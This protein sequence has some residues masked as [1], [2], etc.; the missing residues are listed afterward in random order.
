MNILVTK[1]NYLGDAVTFLPTLAALT[2][3]LPESTITIVATEVGRQVFEGHTQKAAFCTVDRKRIHTWAAS[4]ILLAAIAQLRSRRYACS[5]HSHDEPSFSYLLARCLRIQR[6][7]GFAS[8][9]GRLNWLLSEKLP[10]DGGRNVVDLNL[11]LARRLLAKPALTPQRV[12]VAYTTADASIV[13]K[14]LLGMS[15][16]PQST[17][18]VLHPGAKLP[19]REWG[20]R[21]FTALA[22]GLERRRKV[23][24]QASAMS[25]AVADRDVST[26]SA[27]RGKRTVKREPSPSLLRTSTVP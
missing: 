7:I 21:N 23:P 1:A 11:E 17:F 9:V 24:H 19:Y 6:R 25:V 13:R 16:D 8:P 10:W 4:A 20:L 3:H 15:V 14:R 12:P 22:Q 27:A 26:V 5:L 18:A 2:E